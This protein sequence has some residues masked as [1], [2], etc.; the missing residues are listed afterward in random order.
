MS[1][2]TELIGLSECDGNDDSDNDGL[3]DRF[4]REL[5][6]SV[7][8]RDGD[9]I[10]LRFKNPDGGFRKVMITEYARGMIFSVCSHHIIQAGAIPPDFL[11]YLLTRNLIA[12]IGFGMWG[13]QP[14]DRDMI[15]FHLSYIALAGGLDAATFRDICQSL[16]EEALDF[17]RKVSQDRRLN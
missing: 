3:A 16:C 12:D 5:N 1:F 4:C 9:T 13:M 8:E 15:S 7:D 2:W 11:A 17:D 10:R 14:G 6:W